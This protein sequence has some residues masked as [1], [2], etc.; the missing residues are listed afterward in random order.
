MKKASNTP[1]KS[2]TGAIKSLF[3]PLNTC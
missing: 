3:R 2:N 1:Y